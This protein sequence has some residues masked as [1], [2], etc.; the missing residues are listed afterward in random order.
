MSNELNMRNAQKEIMAKGMSV[1]S[2]CELSSRF[3]SLSVSNGNSAPRSWLHNHPKIVF[4]GM[5]S[6]VRGDGWC[7][8]WALV[9]GMA[10]WK[11]PNGIKPDDTLM[12][13]LTDENQRN[14]KTLQHIKQIVL[15]MATCVN[16]MFVE[17]P[18]RPYTCIGCSVV[19]DEP[20]SMDTCEL[21]SCPIIK[22]NIDNG[23]N[24]RN[25]TVEMWDMVFTKFGI[26]LAIE[27]FI[28]DDV[29]SIHGIEHLKL[30]AVAF[31]VCVELYDSQNDKLDVFGNPENERVYISTDGGHYNVHNRDNRNIPDFPQLRE[32]L[33]EQ[34]NG[35]GV[36]GASLP[37]VF[38]S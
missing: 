35:S 13:I 6:A 31:G 28:Q 16:G 4:R 38:E 20:Q 26:E 21:C 19:I 2:A 30:L 36:D 17:K 27:Q 8:L 9:N 5:Y 10:L 18:R 37:L 34:W 3:S 33:K 11:R 1:E 24:T 7:S 22:D 15:Q 29:D 23:E 32:L 14:P 25:V 12:E